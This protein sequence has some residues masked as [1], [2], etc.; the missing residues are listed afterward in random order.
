MKDYTVEGKIPFGTAEAGG[1]ST[2]G[3]EA[4]NEMKD[5]TVK[6]KIPFGTAE[7]GG[8][9]TAEAEAINEMKDYTVEEKI[10]L[11]TAEAGGK[12]T[13]EVEAITVRLDKGSTVVSGLRMIVAGLVVV[14]YGVFVAIDRTVRR[15][16]WAV[17]VVTMLFYILLTVILFVRGRALQVSAEEQRDSV[18]LELCRV[19]A[20][21]PSCYLQ[22][23]N[24]K[25][26][27][28]KA[29]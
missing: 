15:Y 3:V 25:D 23:E 11:G 4:I 29:H 18:A 6:G 14:I 27:P 16:P 7:A 12:S 13:A 28:Y 1:K 5:Y 22:Y 2:A 19:K 17:I 10:M 8:K 24:R 21:V 26:T 20:A 9:S